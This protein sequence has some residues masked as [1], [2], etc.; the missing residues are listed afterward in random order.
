M[1]QAGKHSYLTTLNTAELGKLSGPD[2]LAGS[3]IEGFQYLPLIDSHNF[4]KKIQG[5][6]I[7]KVQI[8]INLPQRT[9][10]NQV[11]ST[12]NIV[13][14]YVCLLLNEYGPSIPSETEE[15][16]TNLIN[17]TPLSINITDREIVYIPSNYI[18]KVYT[19]PD[20]NCCSVEL[21]GHF[22][23]IIPSSQDL[24]I[25]STGINTF[26][27]EITYTIKYQNIQNPITLSLINNSNSTLVEWQ[28]KKPNSTA[29]IPATLSGNSLSWSLGEVILNNGYIDFELRGKFLTT[30]PLN[31]FNTYTAEFTAS[32]LFLSDTCTAITS[33]SSNTQ[34]VP[35]E[36]L[37]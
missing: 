27:S 20:V 4:E 3:I 14:V 24:G 9:E 1:A 33:Q 12:T 11:T 37:I 28:V 13:N 2:G 17:E 35:N 26:T 6:A 18:T 21:T 36:E 30:L 5:I 19:L 23:E 32:D 22:L 8:A 29:F 34:S 7:D 25:Y 31:A 16:L 15:I 10:A